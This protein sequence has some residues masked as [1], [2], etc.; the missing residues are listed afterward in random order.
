MSLRSTSVIEHLCCAAQS[1]D[2]CVIEP[3][4]LALLKTFVG[5]FGRK[6]IKGVGSALMPILHIDCSCFKTGFLSKVPLP[7]LHHPRAR[8]N[9]RNA[10]ACNIHASFRKL[11]HCSAAD[12]DRLM[13]EWILMMTR[14]AGFLPGPHS[15]ASQKGSVPEVDASCASRGGVRH[16]TSLSQEIATDSE[17]TGQQSDCFGNQFIASSSGS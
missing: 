5:R 1:A 12:S 3:A 6:V 8:S 10:G 14:S 16:A 7:G 15:P 11:W 2:R 17:N 13:C 4:L 9:I